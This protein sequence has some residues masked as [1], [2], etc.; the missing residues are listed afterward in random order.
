MECHRPLRIKICLNFS[1][2][3]SSTKFR[4]IL[5]EN[6]V[7][8]PEVN[9]ISFT[10]SVRAGEIISSMCGIKKISLELGG[11]DAMVIDETADLNLAVNLA[12]EGAFKNSGQRCSSVKRLIVLPSIKEEFINKLIMKVETIVTGDPNDLKTDI[13]TVIDEESA[14]IIENR[15][16][17]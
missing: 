7:S 17:K 14:I 13:G 2:S 1:P 4:S 8:H 6:L 3:N 9:M 15:I 16:I 5:G 11:N 10:G 12:C